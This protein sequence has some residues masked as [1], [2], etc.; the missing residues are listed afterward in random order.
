LI[1]G[2]KYKGEY[3]YSVDSNGASVPAYIE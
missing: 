2:Y 3:Y 1:P